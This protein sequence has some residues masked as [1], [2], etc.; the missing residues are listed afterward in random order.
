MLFTFQCKSTGF[1][2]SEASM[3]RGCSLGR[4]GPLFLLLTGI[5]DY[6]LLYHWA[7]HAGHHHWRDRGFLVKVDVSIVPKKRDASFSGHL[8]CRAKK[9]SFS[10]VGPLKLLAP[11]L[12]QPEPSSQNTLFPKWQHLFKNLST[13]IHHS[14]SSSLFLGLC[15]INCG[16]EKSQD[17]S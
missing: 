3:N 6:F 16:G 9:T 11:I 1:L 12:F 5:N 8:R 14:L 2:H 15:W 13:R 7:A 17:C 10:F 4:L